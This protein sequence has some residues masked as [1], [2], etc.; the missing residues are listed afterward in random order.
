MVVGVGGVCRLGVQQLVPEPAGA[1][2]A[3]LILLNRLLALYLIH[4]ILQHHTE[5]WEGPRARLFDT[6]GDAV[7]MLDR[8]GQAIFLELLDHHGD[9]L[10][11]DIAHGCAGHAG[12]G[13][14]AHLNEPDPLPLLQLAK[15]LSWLADGAH[16]SYWLV[17]VLCGAI[18]DDPLSLPR[19]LTEVGE[20]H[21][22]ELQGLGG[23]DLKHRHISIAAFAPD[24]GPEPPAVAHADEVLET[25]RRPGRRLGLKE[26]ASSQHKA[27]RLVDKAR[28]QVDG[29]L[30]GLVPLRRR[31]YPDHCRPQLVKQVGETRLEVQH[32][33]RCRRGGRGGAFGC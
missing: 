6:G 18:G 16:D 14:H 12:D 19:T 9:H 1:R 5:V 13:D 7:D 29:V 20:S 8:Q 3:A 23:H 28:A 27:F 21:G 10:A 4:M 26:M 25:A 30:E 31:I 15:R 2:P 17:A 33:N 22:G 32:P 24:V 11:V